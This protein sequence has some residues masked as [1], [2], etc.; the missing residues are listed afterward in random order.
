MGSGR[1]GE[2]R[3]GHRRAGLIV[4]AAAL[5]GVA[6]LVVTTIPLGVAAPARHAP[7]EPPPPAVPQP[8]GKLTCIPQHGIRFCPG[9]RTGGLDLRV[10]S[11]DGVPLDADV[12]LPPT[13]AGP[14]PLVVLLHGLGGSKKELETTTDDGA[15][16]DVT[17]ASRGFAVLTYTARGFGTSC[18]TAA[19]RASTPACAKGWIR[20]ADQRY[21][22]RDTQ[23]LAGLLVDEG[24]VE[25]EI[26]VAGV[27]Y[28]A[29]QS[30]EL[31]VLKNR[32]RRTD[33]KLV[34]F[35]SPGRHVPMSVGAVYAMWPWDDLAT[36]LVP[37][38]AL[39]T[40]H[41]TSAAQDRR[42]VGVAKQSW[43]G[44]LYGVT[45]A[46]YLAP[47]GK[48]PTSALTTWERSLLRGEPYKAGG[49]S[50]EALT[51]LS[52]YKSAIGI[53]MPKGGP[54]ATAIQSGWTDTLFPA[55]EALHYASRLR[56]AHAKTPLLMMLDD[57]G[58]GWAHDKP[59]DL[60][61]T[62]AKALAFLAAELQRHG[63]PPTGVVA[64]PTTCPA[65]ASS[66][67]PVTGTSL[68]ALQHGAFAL[69]GRP[70]TVT[71]SGGSPT[72]A[73]DLNAAYAKP[74]CDPM[75]P[76]TAPGTAT[77]ERAAGRA[78]TQLLG[79]VT[80]TADLHVTGRYPEL[81]G[82]LWDVAHDGTR[83]IVALGVVRPSRHDGTVT[84]Q[85]APADWAFA[86]GHSIELQLVGSTAPL[87]RKSNGTFRIRVSKLRATL[88]TT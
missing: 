47:P 41:D 57:V 74:L 31:A 66:G 9:G 85:L 86:P 42:P 78:G 55:S 87:F 71:S 12:A 6:A 68:A 61:V 18:G 14:F 35:T 17:L 54:A 73:A 72:T 49:V 13:G 26:G 69:S 21:E 40:A 51:E 84:F 3:H 82:R 27:S 15:V 88:P 80:V 81:V 77:Y 79:P 46:N 60:A 64:I 44:L 65:T 75:P 1:A 20:L 7:T 16:D 62:N 67:T 24:L 28:G 48:A 32:L 45:A 19:S 38:G 33:G 76:G 59:A 43:D 58:H 5:A 23:Y 53:P 8:F 39:T 52:T 11:F 29:G 37:N 25:P 36:S 10:A 22:V 2:W 34:P 50:T 56:A 83:Q 30:L 4:G 63:R 70:Q